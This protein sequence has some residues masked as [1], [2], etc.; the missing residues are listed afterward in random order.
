MRYLITLTLS[1]TFLSGCDL[2][3][4]SEEEKEADGIELRDYKTAVVRNTEYVFTGKVFLKYPDSTEVDVTN[5]CKYPTLDTS[6][7]VGTKVEYKVTYETSKFVYSSKKYIKIVDAIGLEYIEISDYTESIKAGETYVFDG[8]VTAVYTDSTKKDVTNKAEVSPVDTSKGGETDLVVSYTEDNV[9]KSVT[10][11]I[12]VTKELASISLSGYKS[13]YE[14][15]EE[16]T[17]SGTSVIARYS[18]N[19][20]S[21]VTS[22]ATITHNVDTSKLGTYQI[23]ASYEEDGIK[24]ED[25]VDVAVTEHVPV[26]Q[27][28]AASDYSTSIDSENVSTYEFDGKVIATF[29]EGPTADVTSDCTFTTSQVTISSKTYLRV[30]ISYTDP[31]KQSNKKTTRVDILINYKVTGIDVNTSLKL[32][33]GQTKPLGASVLP[34][35]ASNKD[36]TYS[37]KD[38][39]PNVASVDSSG[40]VTG[41]SVG[42][43]T[44]TVASSENAS[45]KKDVT[46]TVSEISYDDWTLLIYMCGSNLESDYVDD[47]EGGCATMD[48]QEIGSVNGQPNGVNVVVQAGGASKW[49]DTYS[50]V[51][52]A[53][54]A[55]RFHLKNKSY[56]KDEQFDKVN[57]GEQ[58]TLEDFLTWGLEKYPANKVGLIFWNHGGAMTGCCHDEQFNDMLSIQEVDSGIKAA[59]SAVGWTNK[60]EFI[61]YDCCLMQ[62]QDIAGLHSSYAKYQIASEESEWGYGWSYDRW[63]DDLF[64]KKST[65]QILQACVD[66]YET[67]TN[68]GYGTSKNEQTLSYLNLENWGAYETAWEDMASTLSGIITSSSAW[69]TFSTLL[70]SCQRYGKT[71]SYGQIVYPY[72]VFD[73]GSFI[74]NIQTSDDYK[75]KSTLMNKVSTLSTRYSSLVGYEFHGAKSSGSTGLTLFAPVSGYSSQSNYTTNSTTLTTWRS[76]CINRGNW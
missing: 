30:N 18:D 15:D 5:K 16:F 37:V 17:L 41:V 48:L 45:I 11:K 12:E 39:N 1:A 67:D 43:E 75:N 74:T 38:G 23:K 56:V 69:S 35:N 13:S 19:S 71:T 73:V 49:T 55:N 72:D 8:K 46:V 63:I 36:L 25:S 53:Q 2:F 68:I 54:K 29:D 9:T 27:S 3:S 57:M 58:S 52:D 10:E 61:G 44:I 32:G 64:A 21:I 66:G 62:V 20:T 6:K 34:S 70:N 51:I 65:P 4:F 26:L 50:S 28:I 60:F 22:K 7:V 31:N 47:E 24:K 59:R 33:V 42:T 76:L 14:I 40:N